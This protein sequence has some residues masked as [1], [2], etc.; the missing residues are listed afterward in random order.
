MRLPKLYTGERRRIFL[1]LLGNGLLQG[2]LAVVSGWLVMQLFDRL[3]TVDKHALFPFLALASAI[4]SGAFLRRMERIHAEA[5][6]Q[7][8]IRTIRRRLYGHLLGS[9][10]R[11]LRQ[12]RKGALLLKFVGDL[13]ALRRWI[14][15]GLAR[16]LVAGLSVVIALTAL[17]WLHWPFAAGIVC[18]LFGAAAWVVWQSDG[19]RRAI[20]D[21]RRCH[22]TLSAN[23]TEKL[24]SLT[25]IQAFGQAARERRLM[26]RQSGR[27]LQ[28]SVVKAA[29]IGSL[30][31]V[32]DATAG[33]SLVF[34]LAIAYLAPP[35]NLSAGMVAAFIS[36]IGFLTPP[37]RD[38][39]RVQEYLAAAQVA[40]K[41]LQAI[42]QRAPRLR[43]RRNGKP[44]VVRDG[45]IRFEGVSIG[46]ALQDINIEVQGGS[47][48][49]VLGP[50]GSGKSTLLGLV[51]RL[52]D[53]ERGRILI[54]GQDISKAQ[55]ASLRR[56]IAQVSADIPLIRGSLGKNLCYG[57]GPVAPEFLQ[58]LL[59]DCELGR[60]VSRLPGGLRG[61]IQENGANLSQGER[62]RVSLVRALL[63]RP[64]ILLLDEVDA[65]LDVPA[66]RA[67]DTV[68]GSFPG[69]LLM[70]THRGSAL[71]LCDA[72]WQLR[73]GHLENSGK[74]KDAVGRTKHAIGLA[75]D[76]I[77]RLAAG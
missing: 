26:Q 19:L 76:N 12:R 64:K 41:N 1:L 46:E 37:L 23:V 77:G 60:L 20:A 8:Y 50:N 47:R 38:L 22:A 35:Q 61:R 56:Q 15:L 67:L 14:S 55:P 7:H 32:I 58:Q 24:N 52:F 45:I 66:I 28:T 63:V 71:R 59:S 42:A 2:A 16:L 11:E 40:R 34:I 74:P 18:I 3:G 75:G 73:D 29:K 57:A 69:T 54:D 6:G 33:A 17:T 70:A 31:A 48:V 62:V 9:D 65:N 27:L 30:R 36:I 5:L 49:A 25:T 53:P 72:F 44:L 68:I 43:T 21:A 13:S 4:M 39:G 10:P 51:G